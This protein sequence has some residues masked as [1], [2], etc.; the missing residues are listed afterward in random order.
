MSVETSLYICLL[1]HYTQNFQK[2]PME[3]IAAY[4]SQ[5]IL[6]AG[7]RMFMYDFFF[8]NLSMFNISSFMFFLELK[9]SSDFA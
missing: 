8:L 4:I 2:D 7:L 1:Y 5:K 3:L 6:Q 9:Q